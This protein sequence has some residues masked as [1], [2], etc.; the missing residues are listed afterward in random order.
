MVKNQPASADDARDTGLI[1][2]LG[3]F[4]GGGF[5]NPVQRSLPEESH[6]QRSLVGL[7]SMGSQR[8][9]QDGVDYNFTFFHL[10]VLR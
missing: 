6:G 1:P 4:P 9:R 10:Q 2:G 5:S 8:G 7:Q 3:R